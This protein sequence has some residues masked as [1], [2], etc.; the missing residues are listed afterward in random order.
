MRPAPACT[1]AK[2][3]AIESIGA[4][5]FVNPAGGI[6]QSRASRRYSIV[7]HLAADFVRRPPAAG[8]LFRSDNLGVELAGQRLWQPRRGWPR[9]RENP[10]GCLRRVFTAVTGSHWAVLAG[11]SFPGQERRQ[12]ANTWL[13]VPRPTFDAARIRQR[14]PSP[15]ARGAR[16]TRAAVLPV[17]YPI[18]GRWGAFGFST[19]CRAPD[20]AGPRLRRGGPRSLYAL[21]RGGPHRARCFKNRRTELFSWHE[22]LRTSA[23]RL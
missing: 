13:S 3:P 18:G 4:G 15:H 23:T 21:R 19:Q 1:G 2:R 22:V 17:F 20:V 16:C 11:F 14:C 5:D 12:Q 9:C 8:V 10:S 6:Q 7:G